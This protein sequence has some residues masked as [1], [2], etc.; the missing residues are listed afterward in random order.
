MVNYKF[1]QKQKKEVLKIIE[2]VNLGKF[3]IVKINDEIFEECYLENNM[4]AKIVGAK[5]DEVTENDDENDIVYNFTLDFSDF[6][7]ENTNKESRNF[8]NQKT[9]EYNLT[10]TEAGYKPSNCIEN[11]FHSITHGK[12]FFELEDENVLL[13]QYM[14]EGSEKSY[15]EWLEDIV[16]KSR[17]SS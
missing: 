12:I 14:K 13:N 6:E 15:T 8:R 3:P 2:L 1:D 16:L 5:V 17:K 11:V 10:A 9:N 7:K 4:F